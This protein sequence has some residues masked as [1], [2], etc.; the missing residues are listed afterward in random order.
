MQVPNQRGWPGDM[1]DKLKSMSQFDSRDL[2][3]RKFQKIA[4][5]FLDG[6]MGP[7]MV[8]R[9]NYHAARCTGCSAFLA[10]LRATISALHALPPLK[11]PEELKQR[12]RKQSLGDSS[13]A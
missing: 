6:D 4:S 11:A 3:C 5:E 9:F 8:L 7:G 12:I 1:W 2:S 10:T 13:D